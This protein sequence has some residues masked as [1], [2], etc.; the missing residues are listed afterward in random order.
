[1][2]S[3]ADAM[4]V[5]SEI[6]E[7]K[8]AEDMAQSGFYDFKLL[9][10]T[11]YAVLYRASKAGK[12]FFIKT[13]KDNS[14]Q[15]MAMLRRE[16][17]L[18]IGCDHP[19]IVHVYTYEENLPVGVGIVM[20]Y[21]EGR[22]LADYL[23]EDPSMG[24][25]HR[26]FEELL[27][28]V[29]YLHKRGVI[30]NDLKPENILITSADNTLKLIDFGLA[31]NNA[32]FAMRRLGC[33]PQYASPEL[34]AQSS[35]IDARSDIYSL[36]ILMGVMFGGK[37]HRIA[38]KCRRIEPSGRYDNI[39]SLQH[40][41][42]HRNDLQKVALGV[43]AIV[44]FLLPFL[45]LGQT[46]L[47]EHREM[48]MKE[49]LFV[50][51]EQDVEQ[52]YAIAADSITRAV[53]YEFADN[54]ILSFWESL[55]SYQSERIAPIDDVELNAL[56]NNVYL[57]RVNRCHNALWEQARALPILYKSNLS[58]EELQFYTELITTRQPYRPY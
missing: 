43:V 4:V 45:L 2:E 38:E 11:A 37:H 31:D 24:D 34:Q 41:W 20:E 13:T 27:S 58:A 28:A 1:M 32:Q 56:A 29:G 55:A 52:I 16:Y 57:H 36:G 5:E 54:H 12:Y 15:Q 49:R 19:H 46:R 48:K 39:I 6:Y 50:Q 53:Y 26:L 14:D 9:K 17:E 22:T 35:V 51:I 10:T 7:G 21:I 47:V 44:V 40:A 25:L 30:H 3:Q 33:T 42:R 23:S 8:V 18:S